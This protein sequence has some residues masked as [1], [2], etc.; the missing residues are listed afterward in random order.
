MIKEQ[1]N[2]VPFN[3]AKSPVFYGWFVVLWG[4][5]GI[6]MSVP[7]Q[8]MGVSTFTDHL[9]DALRFDR[10][11][12][13]TA[14]LMGTIASS[15]LLTRAGKLYDKIGA[16]WLGTMVTIA[17]GF[18]LIYL[19][20]VDRI[21][22]SF[23]EA[24]GLDTI[25]FYVSFIFVTLGFFMLRFTGQ[26]VLTML[27][28]NMMMKWFNRKRGFAN[29]ISSVFVSMG[30]AISPLVFDFLIESYSWR[31]AWIL[32]ALV[33][34]FGF[35]VVALI[36]F[37]DNPEDCGLEQDG[38]S[39][40]QVEEQERVLHRA[41]KQYTLKEA[42]RSL[43]FWV[44]VVALSMQALYIT[45]FTF[46][47]VSIFES[48]NMDKTVALA[49]FVPTSAI[50]VFISL[51]GGWLSDHIKM[52][53]LLLVFLF[54]QI[55]SLVSLSFLSPG[56]PYAFM[57][58]GNGIVG[59]LFSVLSTVVWPRFYGRKHLGAISGFAMSS[60]VFFSA[61]GPLLFSFS[62]TELGSYAWAAY[63]CLAIV[64]V[65][66]IAAFKA[67]NPQEKLAR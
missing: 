60:L 22:F 30:F 58:I 29:G 32:L 38:D 40:E 42:Q 3:P 27:S 47:L 14:Y 51:A 54:G 31:W 24:L 15:F 66:F 18:V 2:H 56:L 8:T 9:I 17:L 11:E 21:S 65:N 37:R 13:S 57:I 4:T 19:S 34:G 50:S 52:K 61:M 43:P 49:V 63:A 25:Q 35:S 6:I 62:F 41:E 59:G 16:R 28:R 36:F 1:Y 45:G 5:L 39:H 55:V 26:G 48:A 44:M 10:N 12:L 46:N 64:G 53:Y 67:D 7:G 33:A 20:Q 23:A